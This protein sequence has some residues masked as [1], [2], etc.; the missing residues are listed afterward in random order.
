VIAD[1]DLGLDEAIDDALLRHSPVEDE[2]TSAADTMM[3]PLVLDLAE[4]GDPGRG[5]HDDTHPINVAVGGNA[6]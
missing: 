5:D 6:A 1:L 3:Y 4:D 2:A